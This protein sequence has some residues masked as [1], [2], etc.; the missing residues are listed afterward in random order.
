MKSFSGRAAECCG[1]DIT[2]VSKQNRTRAAAIFLARLIEE[3]VDG[4]PDQLFTDRDV[5]KM[6]RPSRQLGSDGP[7]HT[8]DHEFGLL[9]ASV[10]QDIETDDAL[11]SVVG[12]E[13]QMRL[14]G[15][16]D[17]EIYLYRRQPSISLDSV[18]PHPG[19][20]LRILLSHDSS[21]NGAD[22]AYGGLIATE[23]GAEPFMDL[24]A[25]IAQPTL[26][27]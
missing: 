13:L 15:S 17:L 27:P 11:S 25:A 5:R 22:T 2:T 20:I 18:L 1:Y 19:R 7:R 8:P 10:A 12:S 4:K 26:V 24:P 3:Y 23:L 6:L 14:D 21:N 9:L 16:N